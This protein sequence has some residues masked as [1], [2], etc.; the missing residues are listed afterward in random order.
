MTMGNHPEANKE[1]ICK[2]ITEFH[3]LD[4]DKARG[5]LFDECYVENSEYFQGTKTLD[6]AGHLAMIKGIEAGFDPKKSSKGWETELHDIIAQDD[7]VAALFTMH[8]THTN[9]F[10]RVASTGK[11]VPFKIQIHA[12]FD[13]EGKILYEHFSMDMESVMAALTAE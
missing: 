10:A 3:K 5:M 1:T 4:E 7:T 9:K 8:A 11:R 6:K 13:E 2:W 12:F